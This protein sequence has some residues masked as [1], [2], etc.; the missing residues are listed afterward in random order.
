MIERFGVRPRLAKAVKFGELVI[1]AGEV[2]DDPA[3]DLQEQTAAV[4]AK[5]D[6]QLAQCGT[7]RSQLLYAQIWLADMSGFA[8]MNKVWDAWID[9]ERPPAR[10]TVGAALAKPHNLVEIQVVA[11]TGNA[12]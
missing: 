1:L 9:P 3:L 12:A 2:A 6:A 11:A 5:I 7:N 10:A 4:L 8:A